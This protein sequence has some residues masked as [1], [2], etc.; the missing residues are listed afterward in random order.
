MKKLILFLLLSFLMI[1]LKAQDKEPFIKLGRGEEMFQVS[2]NKNTLYSVKLVQLP[3]PDGAFSALNIQDRTSDLWYSISVMLDENK[4]ASS[5]TF[6]QLEQDTTF[7][8]K[9]ISAVRWK[10]I[11]NEVK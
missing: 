9:V 11:I 2:L 3:N 7:I 1:T 10:I 6:I 4:E 8:F 5:Q